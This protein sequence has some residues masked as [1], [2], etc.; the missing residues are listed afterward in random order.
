PYH[1]RLSAL[2]AR[3]R[4]G[5][6]C[7]TMAAVGPPVGPDPGRERQAVCLS[8]GDGACPREWIDS[9]ARIFRRHFPEGVS[10][11]SPF[12]GGHIVRSH[13]REIPWM[14]IELSRD[15]YVSSEEK[16]RRVLAALEQWCEENL[17]M[18]GI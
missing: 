2:A 10:V 9:A 13:A 3:V 5:F 7:H 18:G 11:N 6:D 1:R 4:M 14:Q 17:A 8:D 16:G 12:K 15:P